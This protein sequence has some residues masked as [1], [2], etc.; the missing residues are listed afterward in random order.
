MCF[1]DVGCVVGGFVWDGVVDV[2]WFF[3][4][5]FG[6][7]VDCCLIGWVCGVGDFE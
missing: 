2:F 7:F 5:D 1:D 3:V 4:G 6:L